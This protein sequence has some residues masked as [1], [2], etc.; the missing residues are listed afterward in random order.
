M[1]WYAATVSTSSRS[2]SKISAAALGALVRH[3]EPP[4]V[5]RM[6]IDEQDARAWVLREVSRRL[7]EELVRERDAFVVDATDLGEKRDVGRAVGRR[8]RDHRG[9]RALEAGCRA[10]AS[11]TCSRRDGRAGIGVPAAGPGV[12]SN[13]SVTRTVHATS[14]LGARR[15]R[16]S[17]GVRSVASMCGEERVAVPSRPL[18]VEIGRRERPPS[19]C[20]SSAGN[21]GSVRRSR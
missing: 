9:H 4:L 14:A 13:S 7:R 19:R 12:W 16:S 10:S 18:G 5:V 1:W 6:R 21:G 8:G 11:D 2:C 15:S 20:P 17:R 3:G